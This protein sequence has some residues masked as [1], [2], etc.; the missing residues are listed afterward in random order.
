MSPKIFFSVLLLAVLAISSNAQCGSAY[1]GYYPSYSSYGYGYYPS[2]SYGTGY[3]NYGYYGKR[4]AGF[5]PQ[6]PQGR[7]ARHALKPEANQ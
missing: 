1:G 4:E 7:Q 3:S 2:Y 6:A 5:A